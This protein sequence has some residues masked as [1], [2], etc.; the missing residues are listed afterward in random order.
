[1]NVATASDT[2]EKTLAYTR[3]FKD[4]SSKHIMTKAKKSASQSSMSNI[5]APAPAPTPAPAVVPA[6]A[7]APVSTPV[8]PVVTVQP[9][10]VVEAVKSTPTPTPVADHSVVNDPMDQVIP[11][12]SVASGDNIQSNN[13]T[14]VNGFAATFENIVKSVRQTQSCLREINTA[15]IV[16]NKE[17]QKSNKPIHKKKSMKKVGDTSRSGITQEVAVSK[18]LEKFMGLKTG[19]MVSRT[20]VTRAVTAYIK[21]HNLQEPTNR[22]N[23]ILDATLTDLLNP[24]KDDQVTYFNLQ[25]YLKVHYISSSKNVAGSETASSS[26]AVPSS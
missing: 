24:P 19:E 17:Y 10:P 23:I 5:N 14:Q 3:L 22:R 26:V 12:S 16:L 7:S 4:N 25:R 21:A 20:A 2:P 9:Q 6:P 15:L 1:L 11:Q 8:V 18:E 13:Q